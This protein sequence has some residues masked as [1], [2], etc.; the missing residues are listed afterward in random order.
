MSIYLNQKPYKGWSNK[1][2]CC[3]IKTK[4]KKIFNK[5]YYVGMGI[6]INGKIDFTIVEDIDNL[7]LNPNI[8]WKII[9]NNNFKWNYKKISE[10]TF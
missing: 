1:G 10:N 9:E 4:D 8:S 6:S 7:S 2:E 5:R 3:Y